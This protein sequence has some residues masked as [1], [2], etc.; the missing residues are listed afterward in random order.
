MS[1]LDELRNYVAKLFENATD[2]ETIKQVG[3]VSS[4]IDEIASEQEKQE[5]DY[6]SLL[7]DYKDVVIHQ[8]YKP[9]KGSG[10]MADAPTAFNAEDAFFK[11]ISEN[12]GK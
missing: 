4:K 12:V 5:N 9:N 2:Q 1:K 3:A 6:K 11:A 8:S 10:D 7:N